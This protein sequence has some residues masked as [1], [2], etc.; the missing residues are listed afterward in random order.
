MLQD[1]MS[2]SVLRIGGE[3]P[4]TDISALPDAGGSTIE[5]SNINDFD[6][7]LLGN[8][9][10][11]VSTPPRVASP[12]GGGGGIQEISLGGGGSGG[13]G[14]EFVNLEDTAVSYDVRPPPS[15]GDSIK[16]VRDS[17]PVMRLGGGGGSSS[18]SAFTSAPSMS[19]SIPTAP[20]PAPPSSSSTGWFSGG[21][22]APTP[23]PPAE[24][25]GFANKLK[26][27]FGGGGS[28]SGSN[29][30]GASVAPI[31]QPVYLT[32]EEENAKK[33]EGLTLLERMDRKGIGG[34]K[35]TIA[36]TL[37]EIN[38]EVA[39]RKDSKG[40]EASIRFQRSMMTT[41]TSG[42][43]FL[44]NR[45]DPLG[46]SLDG[47][48]EQV[49][50]NIEDYDEI[51]EELYD[52]YKDKSKVAPEVRLVMSLGLSAAMCHITNTMFKSK[53]PGMD[54]ILRKNPDLARQ[55]AQAA[56]AQAV[57]PGFANF[58]G[59]GMPG[60][61]H[62]RRSGGAG[63]MTPPMMNMRQPQAPQPMP[64]MSSIHEEDRPMFNPPMGSGI[65]GVIPNMDPRGGI[66]MGNDAPTMTA[67]REMRGPSGVEDILRTL[68]TAGGAPNRAVPP[69]AQNL[70]SE[71]L[72]SVHSGMTGVT[73]ETMRRQGL[74]R[75]RKPTTT[76]PT[77]AT[78]TL[79]V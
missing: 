63:N 45:Y 47:W 72:G 44:N 65:G 28:S 70:D 64:S 60:G 30:S 73:T 77:G 55:M 74:N 12:G 49:N 42:M 15:N 58:V 51:F 62:S 2:G 29:G 26:S 41:V 18:S 3:L 22:A 68:E 20:A 1:R 40:L 67:R 17:E 39:R 10:K 19:A 76:Q 6:L 56:A 7:G 13:D 48:S 59:M 36:N 33:M 16:I 52:K 8:Q 9:R 46:L 78:L 57:G 69:P 53:M 54:D 43:E 34:T 61:E 25:G 32:P 23:A 24:S 21:V 79:N 27:L 71:D 50:E 31:Q 66:D 5:I 4:V 38:A 14:I 75:R 35:M 37:D 11:F